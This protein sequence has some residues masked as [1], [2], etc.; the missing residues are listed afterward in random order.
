MQTVTVDRSKLREALRRNRESHMIFVIDT[1]FIDTPT[2]SELISLAVVG[3]DDWRYCEFDYTEHALTPWLREHVVPQLTGDKTTF[4][5][6][7]EE[8][9][10]I[11]P[12]STEIDAPVEFWALCGGYDWYWFC[13]LFGG[14]MNLPET[15]PR[16][17]H[18][19]SLYTSDIPVLPGLPPHHALH[20]A[21]AEFERVLI[22][23]KHNL[24][25]R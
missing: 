25:R 10:R 7:A 17:F 18:D 24:I 1:E 4:Q 3:R 11:I 14:F 21:Q 8:I 12:S 22:L 2:H 9:R 5:N 16:T 23:D 20:D 15:W 6:A 19:L 13:R